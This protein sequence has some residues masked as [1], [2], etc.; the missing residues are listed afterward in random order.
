[1]SHGRGVL[2]SLCGVTV[3]AN[4][5]FERKSHGPLPVTPRPHAALWVLRTAYLP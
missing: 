1:M 5:E 4:V 2:C 3:W